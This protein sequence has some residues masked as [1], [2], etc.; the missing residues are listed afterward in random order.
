MDLPEQISSDQWAE[1]NEVEVPEKVDLPE[2]VSVSEP[3]SESFNEDD[4][5]DK[6][7]QNSDFSLD[8]IIHKMNEARFLNEQR[9]LISSFKGK[10]STYPSKSTQLIGH[11]ESVFLTIT[12]GVIHFMSFRGIMS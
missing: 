3:I 5:E 2:R 10:F 4:S 7:L 12:E 6:I 8:E 1:E 11:L 9:E